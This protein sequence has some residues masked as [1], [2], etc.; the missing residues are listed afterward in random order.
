MQDISVLNGDA[1]EAYREGVYRPNRPFP[2]T[3]GWY[4]IAVET[5]LHRAEYTYRTERTHPIDC[6]IIFQPGSGLFS[7]L[8]EPTGAP[9]LMRHWDWKLIAPVLQDAYQAICQQIDCLPGLSDNDLAPLAEGLNGSMP[10][11]G[12]VWPWWQAT[13]TDPNP[14]G[15]D[16]T[17]LE[18]VR[19]ILEWARGRI[20]SSPIAPLLKSTDVLWDQTGELIDSIDT[21]LE[22][23]AHYS[24]YWVT[25]ARCK[26]IDAYN[27]LHPDEPVTLEE[28]LAYIDEPLIDPDKA[29]RDWLDYL[30]AQEERSRL[31]DQV[32]SVATNGGENK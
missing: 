31:R 4:R 14:I 24:R 17:D 1:L 18:R 27:D 11:E 3:P 13:G 29:R 8:Y 30:D 21:A 5:M 22:W 2:G 9:V 25:Q 16:H 15:L 32:A 10:A 7:N 6:T 23:H 19:T 28:V 20:A 26:A 12:C